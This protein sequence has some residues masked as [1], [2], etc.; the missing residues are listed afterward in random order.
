MIRPRTPHGAPGPFLASLLLTALLPAALFA[1]AL[2]GC[3]AATRDEVLSCHLDADC[4]AGARC[5]AGACQ[6]SAPPSTAFALPAALT[7]NRPVAITASGS[8]PDPGGQV[9]AWAWTVTRLTGGCEADVDVGDAATLQA[10]FWC[11]GTYEVALVATDDT[12]AQSAPVRHVATVTALQGAPS[13]TA[14]PPVAVEHLCAG[15]PLRCGLAAPVTLSATGLASQGGPLSYRWSALPPE[16]SRAG[17]TALVTPGAAGGATLA[18]TTDGGPISGDWRLRVRVEDASGNLAQAVQVV[19]VGNRPPVVEA[20]SVALDHTYDGTYRVAGAVAAPLSDP[21]GDPVE[22][23]IALEEPAG[24]GCAGALSQPVSGAIRLDLACPAPSGLMAAGRSLRVAA[25]DANGGS[26]GAAVA[27]RVLNR[28]P[29]IRLRAGLTEVALDHTVG[30]CPAGGDCYLATGQDPFEVSDPDGDPVS[31]AT[32]LPAVDADRP[33][34]FAAAVNA[35]S[36]S[37]FTFGVP[38][39]WPA[40]F[41]DGAGAGGFRLSATAADPFGASP[42]LAPALPVRVLNRPP[43]PV[44]GATNLAAGHRYDAALKTYLASATLVTFVDPDGDPLVPV[45]SL[46]DAACGRFTEAGGQVSVTCQAAFTVAPSAVPTLGGFAGPHLLRP[47]AS[48]AWNGTTAEVTLDVTSQAPA[49]APFD[50]TVESCACTCTNPVQDPD[51]GLVCL[52]TWMWA[53]PADHTILPPLV[54][55]QDGDPVRSTVSLAPG[56]P[57]GAAISNPTSTALPANVYATLYTPSYPVTVLV[58]VSDGAKS[59]SG[60]WTLRGATCS[61]ATQACTP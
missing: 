42:P 25:T 26:A 15:A 57:A 59:A 8:D 53:V 46:G 56:S 4:G 5:V 45:A 35:L 23:A 21:D 27:V 49:V 37:T 7:T 61:R 48:D 20:G 9:T 28:L 12:G 40:E 41:R 18:L 38:V 36:G 10:V 19:H 54:T 6:A 33:H 24:S 60:A 29:V 22:V 34:A 55:D 30:P 31:V 32:L 51:F 2:S 13:V 14:G 3:G 1:V 43:V 44:D 47:R 11:P 50:G 52:G 58:S 39:A 16:P 17:A